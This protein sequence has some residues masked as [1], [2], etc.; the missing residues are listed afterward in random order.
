MKGMGGIFSLL[1][2]CLIGFV[3]FIFPEH[4]GAESSR[5]FFTVLFSMVGIFFTIGIIM[6]LLDVSRITIK[7]IRR[8]ES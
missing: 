3:G 7:R 2:I 4:L 5:E 6:I 1:I 8:V